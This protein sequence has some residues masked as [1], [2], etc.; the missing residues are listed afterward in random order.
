MSLVLVHGRRGD[1]LARR[2]ARC[3]LGALLTLR[4]LLALLSLLALRTGGELARP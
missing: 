3:T 4:A 1:D 2:E